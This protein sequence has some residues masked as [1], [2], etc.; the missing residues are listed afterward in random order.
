MAKRTASRALPSLLADKRGA[1]VSG[2]AQGILEL[3]LDSL[4]ENP[5]QP[6]RRFD[7]Q[8][9]EELATS[10][11]QHG[12]VQ[13]VVVTKEAEGYRLVV[14]ERR[15]RAARLAGLTAI[16]A[17]VR[18]IAGP[19]LL[20]IAL[21]ENLQRHDLNP[22]EEAQ[23]YSFLLRELQLTQEELGDRLGCSR[24]AVTNSL[25]LLGLPPDI[26]TDLEAGVLSAGHART[27]LA[28]ETERGQLGAWHHFKTEGFSVRQAEEYIRQI[29]AG[30]RAV[31]SF[32]PTPLS[33]DWQ[34]V[35][36]H[37]CEHLGT[38]VRIRKNRIELSYGSPRELERLVEMLIYSGEVAWQAG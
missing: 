7:Q 17:L 1:S 18:E 10:I 13:P 33:P 5:L 23:A 32:G 20:E 8:K 36:D 9:L 34:Q 37:L 4:R 12:V 25:R 35:Q 22:I 15:C 28:L 29:Q 30:P 19:D 16:P 11:R 27:L 38:P 6:R 14:G 2:A 24:P 26:R 3:P 21:I 31:R